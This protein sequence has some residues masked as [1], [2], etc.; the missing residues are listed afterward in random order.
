MS[1]VFKSISNTT[2]HIGSRYNTWFYWALVVVI[3][4]PKWCYVVVCALLGWSITHGLRTRLCTWYNARPARMAKLVTASD[5]KSAAYGLRVRV[6]FRAPDR[7]N[8]RPYLVRSARARAGLPPAQGGGDVLRGVGMP[9]QA[10]GQ[11]SGASVGESSGPESAAGIT[12]GQGGGG[13]QA[14]LNGPARKAPVRLVTP[15]TDA[16][17]NAD[18]MN[19]AVMRDGQRRGHSATGTAAHAGILKRRDSTLPTV[20]RPPLWCCAFR[21]GA[22]H[23]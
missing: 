7:Q 8:S 12:R 3:F 5:L 15:I 11:P 1:K 9:E 20:P 6:P 23:G 17:T 2:K 22:G 18:A 14:L 16:Y 10:S 21:R 13:V 19:L 4:A